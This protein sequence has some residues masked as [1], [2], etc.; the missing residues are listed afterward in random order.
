MQPIRNRALLIKKNAVNI[1]VNSYSVNTQEK[2]NGGDK[3]RQV[4]TYEESKEDK[5]LR[6]TREKN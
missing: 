3:Y 5:V 4:N 2:K 6:K 1:T